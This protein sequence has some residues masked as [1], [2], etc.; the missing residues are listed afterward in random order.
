MLMP[1]TEINAP[2]V[3]SLDTI[4]NEIRFHSINKIGILTLPKTFTHNTLK[5]FVIRENIELETLLET[6]VNFLSKIALPE[7]NVGLVRYETQ[8][9]IYRIFERMS[10]QGGVDAIL[11]DSAELSLT[12]KNTTPPVRLLN[13]IRVDAENIL[14]AISSH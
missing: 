4:I 11:I 13:L 8:H 7:L 12:V 6:E 14:K 5:C 3:T 2:I 1:S 9:G 10:Y